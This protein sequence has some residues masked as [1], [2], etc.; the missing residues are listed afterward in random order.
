MADSSTTVAVVNNMSVGQLCYAIL[1][2]A[3]IFWTVTSVVRFVVDCAKRKRGVFCSVLPKYGC[4]KKL[5]WT[6]AAVILGVANHYLLDERSVLG[7]NNRATLIAG[8]L[9]LAYAAYYFIEN[10]QKGISK[11]AL[12]HAD[13]LLSEFV[14]LF[15]LVVGCGAS[16][17]A[18]ADTYLY[19]D[20]AYLRW[21][22]YVIYGGVE[23]KLSALALF[24]R[25]LLIVF[26]YEKP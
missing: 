18:M 5:L 26:K 19:Y 15:W 20:P 25:V 1:Y 17:T 7:V 14:W 22:E 8:L 10:K 9:L 6:V 4:T 23:P 12:R 2:A 16:I 24:A 13:K 3:V 21:Y 11:H